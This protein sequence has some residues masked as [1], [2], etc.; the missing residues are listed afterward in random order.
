MARRTARKGPYA[1]KQFWGCTGYP[2]CKHIVNIDTVSPNSESTET[3][4][5]GGWESGSQQDSEIP[6]LSERDFGS[7]PRVVSAL[8]NNDREQVRF[9]QSLALPEEYVEAIYD[10]ETE[11]ELVRSA[12]QWRLDFPLPRTTQRDTNLLQLLSVAETLLTRGAVSFCSPRLEKALLES[13]PGASVDSAIDDLLLDLTAGP[14]KCAEGAR[15]GSDYETRFVQLLHTWPEAVD[16]GWH[17]VPQIHIS[18]LVV[19]ADAAAAERV[20]FLLTRVGS[21]PIVVEID[22]PPHEQHKETDDARDNALRSVGVEVHRISTD[23]VLSGIGPKISALR[24]SLAGQL[25]RIPEDDTVQLMRTAKLV[26]Q[27][28]M[29]LLEGL[30]GGWIRTGQKCKVG[31]LLP[32]RLSGLSE[33]ERLVSLAGEDFIELLAQIGELYG[34]ESDFSQMEVGVVGNSTSN[35]LDL[36]IAAD[37]QPDSGTDTFTTPV[38]RVSN[39]MVPAE[40]ASPLST[41]TPTSFEDPSQD[42]TL[43]FL[44]YLFRKKSFWEG[45]WEAISRT[46][47]GEDSVVLLPT[48]GGKSMVFQLAALL[49]PGRCLIIE[50]TVALM[51]DQVDNLKKIGVDRCASI[52]SRLGSFSEREPVVQAFASGHYIFTYVAPERLQTEQFREALTVLTVGIPVSAIVVDEAH[53]VSE[54]GHSFRTAYLNVGRTSREYC[55]SNGQTPPLVAMTGTASRIV[56]KDVQRE[57]GI[58]AF[59][60][61]ITPNTFDRPNLHYT[62]LQCHSSEKSRRVQGFINRLP[63]DFR[64]EQ[65][66]FLEP[67]RGEETFC[68]LIFCPHI[69][70]EFGV[71]SQ[72]REIKSALGMNVDVYS[73][74][75][76]RGFDRDN[77]EARKA[78]IEGDFKHNRTNVL[79]CTS[80]F[81]MGIDKPNIRYTIHL[82]LPASIESFYQEAGRAGRSVKNEDAHCAIVISDDDPDRSR[83]LLAPDTP[84]QELARVVNETEWSD[85]DDI[86]RT[87]FFYVGSFQGPTAEANDLDQIIGRIGDLSQRRVAPSTS[88]RQQ[89]NKRSADSKAK[90][91]ME[92]VLHRLLVIG[93]VDDYTISFSSK[94][95]SVRLS[96]ASQKEIVEALGRY[97]GA[98]QARLGEQTRV[99]AAALQQSDHTK[100]VRGVC[101]LLVEFIYGTLELARR[102]QIR[103]MYLAAGAARE[104]ED[105][106][107]RILRHL[108]RSE[109][110]D[111][112]DELRGSLLGG[113]D[114]IDQFTDEIVSPNQAAALRGAVARSLESYPDVPGLLLLRGLAEALSADANPE[115]VAENVRAC[116]RFARDQ[117]ALEPALLGDAVARVVLSAGRRSGAADQVLMTALHHEP[118]DRVFVRELVRRLP[119]QYAGLPATWLTHQLIENVGVVVP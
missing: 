98:Y 89:S 78:Q 107:G 102:A 3:G 55:S 54:W 38:V 69:N 23:E 22:G 81:G 46:L 96:G 41:T 34:Q 100:F 4:G 103:E 106:R 105:L 18:A 92:K 6:L 17:V 42:V 116:L 33:I 28:Q 24:T 37:G 21:K 11:R 77:W 66:T 10:A 88:W 20:D 68:G 36:L 13:F 14:G 91:R 73:G 29:S 44:Q 47:R 50:P 58:T 62:I 117:Y 114:K 87:L 1:G 25:D 83:Y 2:R 97:V 113:L 94:E 5:V 53:C 40:I 30:R 16:G 32:L 59:D 27:I 15:L 26:S 109:F 104:G 48:G 39:T 84:V 7:I 108:E 57:L 95:F 101:G 31:V 64:V 12:A 72:A 67:N 9:V 82:N 71:V 8:P 19:R 61:I 76:P 110:D 43:W 118:T 99:A 86:I 70:G 60:A 52:S 51:E 75:N 90:E 111:R 80:A 115:V 65:A 45:Q 119:P 63:S 79:A 93:V 35:N 112:L 85:A 56:L 49:L 74:G